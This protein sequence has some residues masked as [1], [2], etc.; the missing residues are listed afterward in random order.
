VEA[1]KGDDL[2]ECAPPMDPVEEEDPSV[3]VPRTLGIPWES[4]SAIPAE[5]G[6]MF[7]GQNKFVSSLLYKLTILDQ[8]P[9]GATQQSNQSI[10]TGLGLK[11]W[12]YYYFL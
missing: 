9:D 12:I 1:A 7:V 2:G 3:P 8:L 5:T 11:K 6:E 10:V 4:A